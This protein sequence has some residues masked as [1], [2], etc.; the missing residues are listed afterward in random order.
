MLTSEEVIGRQVGTT[1]GFKADW[2]TQKSPESAWSPLDE[3]FVRLLSV[4]QEEKRGRNERTWLEIE[5]FQWR[6]LEEEEEDRGRR[7]TGDFCWLRATGGGGSRIAREIED[8]LNNLLQPLQPFDLT[9]KLH[10]DP[11]LLNVLLLKFFL[12]LGNAAQ[13]SNIKNLVSL[14]D[15]K[16]LGLESHDCHTLI[17]QLLSV[18]IRSVLE[19]PVRYMKMLNGYVQ[20]RTHPEGCITERYIAEEAV[21]FCTEHLYDVSTIGVPSSQKMGLSKH[22]QRKSYLISGNI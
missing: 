17:Q 19:K 14:Q 22:Y 8:P 7:L 15:S 6:L 21:E 12:Q 4:L 20:S 5:G 16:L 3:S 2:K 10:A 18:A 9:Y 1:G 11:F 13:D